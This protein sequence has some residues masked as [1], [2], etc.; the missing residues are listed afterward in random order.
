MFH[1]FFPGPPKFDQV[2]YGA[3]LQP[4]LV[5]EFYQGRQPRHGAVVVHD[6]ADDANW[7]R[8]GQG[9][10]IDGRLGMA[11]A[12][13]YAAGFGAQREHVTGLHQVV[14]HRC[15]RGHDANGSG[16]VG[17]A[18]AAADATGC[19]HGNLEIGAEN[20]AVLFHHALDTEL[21]QAFTRGRNAN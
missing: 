5:G 13:Q 11:R 20:F 16:T 7:P 15:G 9:N 1:Q 10:E 21:L 8:P 3:D 19:V 6:F 17:R 12:L 18:D 2:G 4:V 14:R